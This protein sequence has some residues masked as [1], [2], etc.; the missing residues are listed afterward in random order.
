MKRK[1]QTLLGL[2]LLILFLTLGDFLALH[3][4]QN[5]YISTEALNYL[6][7]TT[8]APLPAWTATT[9]EWTMVAI[10]FWGRLALISISTFLLWRNIK[11][12]NI[13]LKD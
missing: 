12:V 3:D 8:S 5:D 6:Q 9:P 4:I 1:F 11:N 10:S 2:N 13:Q 7:I